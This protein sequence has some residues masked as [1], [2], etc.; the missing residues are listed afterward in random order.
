MSKFKIGDKVVGKL[1]NGDVHRYL[2]PNA[3]YT[4]TRVTSNFI[5][6]EGEPSEYCLERIKQG[7]ASD[8]DWKQSWEGDWFKLYVKESMVG[9][10]EHIREEILRINTL[11]EKSKKDIEEAEK[12]RESFVEQLRE[13][14]FLLYEK[15]SAGQCVT[16]F[17]V[18]DVHVGDHLIL[19]GN[20]RNYFIQQG[21]IVSVEVND[22]SGIPFH[23]RC[24]STGQRDWVKLEDVKRA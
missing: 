6:I 7:F 10:A 14:G 21:R 9:T 18:D 17:S 5:D 11:I 24:L 22:K 8:K 20:S 4:V 19:T 16:S 12:K 3:V 15:D 13:K 23:V 1:Y 2:I